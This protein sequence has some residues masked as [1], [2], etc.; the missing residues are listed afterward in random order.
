MA[1]AR[2]SRTT[3]STMPEPKLRLMSKNGAAE[4]RAA[5]DRLTSAE[6]VGGVATDTPDS[7]A[8]DD[9]SI[10][11]FCAPRMVFA[12]VLIAELLAVTL[13][14]A[15]PTEPFLTELARISLFL[16]WLAL[17]SAALLC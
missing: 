4:A 3:R 13:S 12:V 10:P 7:A 9:L 2:T 8:P 15:R 11:D 5:S 14:L 16:Q 6:R 17:T 1:S